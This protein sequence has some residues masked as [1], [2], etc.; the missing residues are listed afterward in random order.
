[1]FSSDPDHPTK[2]IKI[3]QD[4]K[5]FGRQSSRRTSV[6]HA[7]FDECGGLTGAVPFNWE[8][9]P[10]TPKNTLASVAS[11]TP[12]PRPLTPPPSRSG[13]PKYI[14][15]PDNSL[16]R[17]LTSPLSQAQPNSPKNTTSPDVSFHRPLP[18]PPSF[19]SGAPKNT[20]FPDSS[21]HPLTPPPLSR[22]GTINNTNF[23]N[24]SILSLTPPP[25]SQTGTPKNTN[26]PNISVQPLTPPPSSQSDAQNNKTV[27]NVAHNRSLTPPPSYN[28][29]RPDTSTAEPIKL[30]RSRSLLLYTLLT[31]ILNL[32]KSINT[33]SSS[34][35]SASLSPSPSHSSL[36]SRSW[37]STSRFLAASAPNMDRGKRS[38]PSTPRSSFNEKAEDEEDISFGSSNPSVCFSIA[39]GRGD[40]LRV[41]RCYGC[42][43]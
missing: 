26:F 2:N 30:K 27:S 21:H 11:D 33:M 32:R 16:R 7:S 37:S 39:F 24:I 29:E 36:S 31:K 23:P 12:R 8:S 19:Q 13:A 17:T 6:S 10:G 25:S 1:M 3:S 43:S 4:D 40:R 28:F 20:N 42:S 34:K 22:S 15:F 38:W 41:V 18:P 35:S 14:T 9:Q 5:F